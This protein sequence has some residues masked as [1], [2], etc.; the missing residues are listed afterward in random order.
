METE[1]EQLNEKEMVKQEKLF[2]AKLK[3]DNKALSTRV[4]NLE[5]QI[6]FYT[7]SEQLTVI[8]KKL[9][10]DKE[11]EQSKTTDPEEPLDIEPVQS[12]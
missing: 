1:D 3:Q 11:E 12:V 5:L 2:L 4:E 6:K 10:L 7:Y 8:L 9:N